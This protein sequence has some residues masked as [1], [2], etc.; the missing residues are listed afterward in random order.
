MAE[1]PAS[2]AS[3]GCGCL[4]VVAI[5]AGLIAVGIWA[6]GGGGAMGAGDAVNKLMETSIYGDGV[7]G[8]MPGTPMEMIAVKVPADSDT[9]GR[10]YWVRSRMNS[11]S[12]WS[13]GTFYAS[14]DQ[15][16]NALV[17]GGGIKEFKAW[18]GGAVQ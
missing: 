6:C 16:V 8:Q 11:G 15:A 4:F 13:A 3:T 9:G 17:S 10:S 5:L 14:P 2:K 12:E 18:V 1:Q 7:W